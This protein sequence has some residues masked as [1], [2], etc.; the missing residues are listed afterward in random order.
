M[1]EDRDS[2]YNGYW[3]WWERGPGSESYNRKMN[4]DLHNARQEIWERN[5]K[6]YNREEKKKKQ[7]VAENKQLKEENKKL[8]KSKPEF[9]LKTKTSQK[10]SNKNRFHLLDIEEEK[11]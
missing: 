1:G 9:K 3:D 5:Q 4:A 10:K 8:K 6:E 7:I 11:I 2:N